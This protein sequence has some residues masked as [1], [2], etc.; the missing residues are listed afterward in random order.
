MTAQR[1][2]WGTH[3]VDDNGLQR[4]PDVRAD[5]DHVGRASDGPEPGVVRSL[6]RAL[7]ILDE[8]A[9]APAGL[10]LVELSRRAGI[11]KST[12]HRLV[13]TLEQRGFVFRLPGGGQYVLGLKAVGA[14]NPLATLI[15][16]TALEG[17]AQHSGESVNLGM[18]HGPDVVYVDRVESHHALRW[19]VTVGSR[20]PVHCSSMGKAILAE[21]PPAT[22]RGL[23]QS[24]TLQRL[25]RNT[26]TDVA[27]LEEELRRVH[28]DGYAVDDEE[29]MD[30]VRCIAAAVHRGNSV[31]GAVSIAGPAM[32]FTRE[33]ALAQRPALFDTVRVVAGL[34]GMPP[35]GGG[36]SVEPSGARAP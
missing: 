35:L 4:L 26:I 25:T 13:S 10:G 23:L 9:L 2:R 29:Y 20:V 8:L 14:I 5:T 7:T 30:G 12:A 11:A 21:L 33:V 28:T 1:A 24:S 19:G 32:R 22:R 34:L 15:L 27:A 36:N 31:I 6:D 3:N 17:L 16:H 18:L